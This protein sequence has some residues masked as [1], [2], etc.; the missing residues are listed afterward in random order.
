MKF[1]HL[2]LAFA[3]LSCS[4]KTEDKAPFLCPCSNT[5][6]CSYFVEFRDF[7]YNKGYLSEGD[8]GYCDLYHKMQQGKIIIKLDEVWSGDFDF[9]SRYVN[10]FESIRFCYDSI[11]TNNTVNFDSRELINIVLLEVGGKQIDKASINR[12]CSRA[13]VDPVAE[14]AMLHLFFHQAN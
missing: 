10:D 5:R 9:R 2:V 8:Q 4:K 13:K 6:L 12:V 1:Y 11:Y 3:L 7:L 14:F